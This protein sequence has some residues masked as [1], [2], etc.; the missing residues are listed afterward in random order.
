MAAGWRR[1]LASPA[2]N[3]DGRGPDVEREGLPSWQGHE[4]RRWLALLA[5]EEDTNPRNPP[6]QPAL[7]LPP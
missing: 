7:F 6:P 3:E 5:K 1:S 2:G 4:Y